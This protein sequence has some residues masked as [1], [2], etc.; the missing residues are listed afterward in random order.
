ML[1]PLHP[2]NLVLGL[3]VWSG[4]FVFIYGG[5]AVAC[6][7]APP[8]LEKGVMS[9]T[10]ILLLVLGL[11]LALLLLLCARRCWRARPA[12]GA[13]AETG[14]SNQ[15]FIG[16]AAAAVY[17]ASAV[18]TLAVAMPAVTLPPCV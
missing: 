7:V 1:P 4:W 17:L 3:I 15:R 2:L 11:L 18:A 13:P 9:W 12:R 6:A 5:L 8:D 14:K 10:N 16:S